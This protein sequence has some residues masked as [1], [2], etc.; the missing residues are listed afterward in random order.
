MVKIIVVDKRERDRVSN[1]NEEVVRKSFKKFCR[2]SIVQYALQHF[3][4]LVLLKSVD[5]W[6]GLDDFFPSV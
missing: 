3:K 4:V 2:V 5:F 6:R 1:L